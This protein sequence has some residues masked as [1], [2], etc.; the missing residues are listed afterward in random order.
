MTESASA[1]RFNSN[2][3]MTKARSSPYSILTW[4]ARSIFQTEWTYCVKIDTLNLLIPICAC[5]DVNTNVTQTC[6]W[7]HASFS[8]SFKC[9]N[10][11]SEV[12]TNWDIYYLLWPTGGAVVQHLAESKSHSR[13]SQLKMRIITL[14]PS[15]ENT[16]NSVY[17]LQ[18]K[19]DY[20][21]FFK[22]NFSALIADRADRR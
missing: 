9:M 12:W 17:F 3:P 8:L 13:T 14:W 4:N 2:A 21:L 19:S 5:S 16:L 10:V 18:Q 7:V 15:S 1:A 20:F 11:I 22:I 6:R